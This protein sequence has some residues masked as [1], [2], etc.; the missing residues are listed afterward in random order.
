MPITISYQIVAPTEAEATEKVTNICYEQSVE[1][2][3]NVLTPEIR[4][5]RLGKPG[6]L[7]QKGTHLWVCDIS[8]PE[9]NAGADITQFLNILFGNV[10]MF[11]GVKISGIDWKSCKNNPL[12]GPS[13]GI[14]GVKKKMDIQSDRALSCTALK[15]M[16]S[17]SEQ[18]AE[19]AYQF[20]RGGIDIIKDDHGLANQPFSPFK[21]RLKAC[22][23]AVK[24]ANDKTG[25]QSAYYPNV[26]AD[27]S[28]TIRRYEQ[29]FEAGAG[30]VLLS[31]HLCGLQIMHELARLDIPLPIMAHPAFSGGLVQ[32]PTHG[33]TKSFLYGS[34]WR[35]FGADFSIYPNAGGRFSFTEDECLGVN[36]ACRIKNVVYHPIYP[37][38][39]GGIQRNTIS[40]LLESYGTQTVFLIGGSLYQHPKGLQYA[41]FEISTI[42]N[43]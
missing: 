39:G 30:G 37:T 42:L 13:F 14:E 22:T 2:P 33:F 25:F 5:T 21:E 31:P 35:A 23:D 12:K 6:S 1:L 26:T 41:S 28:E 7:F 36:R 4:E 11:E 27:G 29:A 34:L 19:Y 16:G 17:T 3:D 32:N 38:P 8:F 20:A 40:S 10:S 43:S 24:K 15:P 9:E 18:L